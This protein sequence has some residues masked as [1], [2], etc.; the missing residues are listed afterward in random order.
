MKNNIYFKNFYVQPKLPNNLEPL[1]ELSQNVWSTWDLDAYRLFSRIDPV[2]F[3]TTNHNPVKLLQQV[4]ES[5]LLELSH[6]SGFLNEMQSVYTKFLTYKNFE[7]S[8]VD[9]QE[10]THIF[11]SDSI[12]AY[13]SM[14]F[15][16]HESL[17]IYSGGL[18]IL[19]GDHIKAASDFNLPLIGFGLLYRYGYFSQKIDMDGMQREIY[20]ENEWYSKPVHK[21]KDESGNETILTV[22]VKNENIFMKVWK[23]DVG[24][25]PIYL[26]DTNININNPKYQTI[27]DHLYVADK[28]MRLLQEIVLA[29]GT[30][31]LMKK[32]NVKPKIYHLNE[33][34]S[35]FII[36]N[37]LND[38]IVNEKFSYAQAKEII[39]SSTV[40]TTHT[41]VPAGNEKFDMQLVKSYLEADIQSFGFDFY[42]FAEEGKVNGSD[43]F[44]LPALAIRFSKYINGVSKLHSLISKEMWHSIYPDLYETEMPIQAITN[45][46]HIQSWISRSITRLFDRYIGP[47]YRHMGE[48]RS[49]WANVLSI[50]LLEIWAAHQQ[51]KEQVIGFIRNRL[52]N[53]LSFRSAKYGK[54]ANIQHVLN[55]NVLTIGFARRFATYKRA[56]LLLKDKD[57]L[58][59][60]LKNPKYPMQFVIAGKAHPADDKGKAMI[61]ELIR[62]IHENEV[63][64]HIVF[65][66][67]YDIN[68]ARHLVQGVDVWLNN[69]IRPLEASG[70]SGMKA[71]M[72]G[73]LNFSV[74]DGWW[75]ECY[76]PD[77]GWAISAGENIEDPEIRDH[78]EANEI[79]DL[80]ENEIAPLYYKKDQNGIPTEW[81]ERMRKSIYDVGLGFNIHRMLR[82]Y[83]DQFYI[84]GMHDLEDLSANNYTKLNSFLVF[85]ENVNKFWQYVKFIDAQ[86]NLHA[87]EMVCSGERV[88]ITVKV[89]IGEAPDDLFIVEVFYLNH[90]Q[91]YEIIPLNLSSREKYMATFTGKF[92]INGSGKQQFNIRLTPNHSNLSS[93]HEYVKWYFK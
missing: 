90:E 58:L 86:I 26:F 12:I 41:P 85:K 82:D 33:G 92:Q 19:S 30:I 5:R 39:R 9:A 48:K 57:R 3:R 78:M 83:I 6:E 54:R 53:S 89:D 16:L 18:G 91:L 51:R 77:N 14:E 23:I 36:I 50:P 49:I 73:V 32:M 67:N 35:A 76:H 71:G 80:L 72:N 43:D 34:H 63:E 42:A 22:R 21:I 47:D 4:K 64:D 13:L 29:Y 40:F 25:V 81:V 20:E 38:L 31:E 44:W 66:E 15:G 11:K 27:T 28:E 79:Y 65:I 7:G 88:H 87:H 68:I 52:Q 60:L 70:T 75:P 2:L 59:S 62:F 56:N 46:V 74:L 45:G 17:P 55:Q 93:L 69:P 24:T 37:R 84:P 61:Q 1:D 10:T 8:Y